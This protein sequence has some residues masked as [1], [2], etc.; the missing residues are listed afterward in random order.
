MRKPLGDLLGLF[1]HEF[2]E[3]H[4]PQRVELRLAAEQASLSDGDFVQQFAGVPR[5][6]W[7]AP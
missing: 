4:F 6:G 3:D 2:R 7:D 1:R 5:P